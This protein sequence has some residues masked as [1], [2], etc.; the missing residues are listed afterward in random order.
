[1][2]PFSLFVQQSHLYAKEEVLVE[3]LAVLQM[4][5]IFEGKLSGYSLQRFADSMSDAHEYIAEWRDVM[6]E[7]ARFLND[8]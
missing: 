2:N 1:M 6:K 5:S 8:H 4:R 3:R 7:R